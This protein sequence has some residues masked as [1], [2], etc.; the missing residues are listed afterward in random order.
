VFTDKGSDYKA[1]Q[2]ARKA[3]SKLVE[4]ANELKIKR[5]NH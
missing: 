5:F 3:A 4:K 2:V 1:N